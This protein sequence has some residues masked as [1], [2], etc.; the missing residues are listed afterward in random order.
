LIEQGLT[1]HSTQFSQMSETL[2]SSYTTGVG[3]GRA[4]CPFRHIT[5]QFRDNLPS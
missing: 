4:Q 5:V 3:L 1:S 2:A